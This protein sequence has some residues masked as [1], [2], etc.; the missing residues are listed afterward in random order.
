MNSG[1]NGTP[2]GSTPR[3]KTRSWGSVL[4]VE[5]IVWCSRA[6]GHV[7]SHRARPSSAARVASAV[8]AVA[9]ALPRAQRAQARPSGVATFSIVAS[10]E[11]KVNVKWLFDSDV[12][13]GND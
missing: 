9:A 7:L 6:D 1:C 13:R 5:K 11:G 10:R 2:R 8:T 4:S 12:E 3:R